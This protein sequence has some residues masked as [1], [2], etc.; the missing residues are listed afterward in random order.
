MICSESTHDAEI[1]FIF[2]ILWSNG[3][4]LNVVQTVI[5]NKITERNKIKQ[6]SVQK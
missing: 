2:T 4:P 1:K 5:T 3:F 6:A